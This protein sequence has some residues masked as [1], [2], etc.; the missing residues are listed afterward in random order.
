MN[1]KGGELFFYM[2]KEGEEEYF[3]ACKGGC[4]FLSHRPIFPNPLPPVL[5]GCIHQKV[6]TSYLSTFSLYPARCV[7]YVYHYLC[8]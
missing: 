3:G 4:I 6:Y 5:K 8:S 7:G 2:L 1:S